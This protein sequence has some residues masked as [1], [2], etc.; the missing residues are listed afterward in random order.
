MIDWVS[1]PQLLTNDP[2]WSIFFKLVAFYG[3]YMIFRGVA[4]VYTDFSKRLTDRLDS[5]TELA[6]KAA[7]ILTRKQNLCQDPS[8]ESKNDAN[9]T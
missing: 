7:E 3:I 9:S 2:G 1:I 8:H 4:R 5:Q 6:K